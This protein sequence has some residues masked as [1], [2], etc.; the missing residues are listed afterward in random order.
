M[1]MNFVYVMDPPYVD[2]KAF[3]EYVKFSLIW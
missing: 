3:F 2:G 1:V